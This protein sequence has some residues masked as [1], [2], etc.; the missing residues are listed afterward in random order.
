MTAL[1]LSLY[2]THF[3][4][5][6]APLSAD[7]MKRIVCGTKGGVSKWENAG[8]CGCEGAYFSFASCDLGY[9]P[10]SVPLRLPSSPLP[11]PPP[12]GTM[13]TP[14]C[15]IF[16]FSLLAVQTSTRRLHVRHWEGRGFVVCLSIKTEWWSEED[17]EGR[18]EG[19]GGQRSVTKVLKSSIS[20]MKPV[21]SLMGR[22]LT[23]NK[24]L[25]IERT[26]L[27]NELL[28]T[29]QNLLLRFE[30]RFQRDCI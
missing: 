28:R 30:I 16:F 14:F 29:F 9:I 24:H 22:G 7:G 21:G 27:C 11:S 1:F 5:L 12:H 19:W 26:C 18:S 25:Q 4:S 6:S 23:V 15:C 3:L 8:G 17:P 2:I 20:N 13:K 10:W